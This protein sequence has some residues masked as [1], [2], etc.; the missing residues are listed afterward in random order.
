M[1]LPL[2]AAVVGEIR[3]RSWERLSY[4]LWVRRG[5]RDERSDL[6]AWQ[7]LLPPT[8]GFTHLT[9]AAVRGWWLPVPLVH[10]VFAA[11]PE[12]GNRYR[13]RG[14]I[15]FRHPQPP[16]LEFWHGLRVTTAA[17]TLLHAAR[18]LALLDLVVLGDSALRS[19]QITLSDLE[20]IA[21]Q[22]RRGVRQLR[23]LI[24]LLDAR[25]ESPWESIMRVLHRAAGIPVTPQYKIYDEYG[26]FVA[27]ADLR[28]DGT[29]RLQEYDGAD[30][31]DKDR[32]RSDLGRDRALLRTGWERAGYTSTDVLYGGAA[33]IADTDRVLGREFEPGQ[34]AAWNALIAESL[35]A[36]AG[37]ARVW[38]RW[39]RK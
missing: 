11:M 34:L 9:A 2:D 31:R 25:S 12:T 1:T 37:R 18:D 29:R 35:H 24:P 27:R 3:L 16:M 38:R 4:G 30:H 17:D 39:R 36:P 5:R 28:I 19:K 14:L 26:D 10:P 33:I 13:R 6:R 22:R 8:A 32:H 21:R 15:V 20:R 7:L 23:R